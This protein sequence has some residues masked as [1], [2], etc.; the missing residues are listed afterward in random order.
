MTVDMPDVDRSTL[1]GIDLFR[2]PGQVAIVTGGS[3]GLGTVIAAALA[4]AWLQAKIRHKTLSTPSMRQLLQALKLNWY[5]RVTHPARRIKLC[6]QVHKAQPTLSRLQPVMA[7]A[8]ALL[9]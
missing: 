5:I 6:S 9:G 2:M 7:Q 4:S 8:V 3:R 1:P